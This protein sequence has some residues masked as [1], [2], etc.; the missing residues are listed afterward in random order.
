MNGR[1]E[2]PGHVQRPRQM[3]SGVEREAKAPNARAFAPSKIPAP[4]GTDP[5]VELAMR[6]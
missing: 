6:Q 3:H 2:Y 4:T 5:V 1:H